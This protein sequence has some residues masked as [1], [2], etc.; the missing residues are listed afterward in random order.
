MSWK[1]PWLFWAADSCLP[2]SESTSQSRN[3]VFQARMPVRSFFDQ[4][5]APVSRSAVASRTEVYCWEKS[6]MPMA[7]PSYLQGMNCPW[8]R[9]GFIR[10]AGSR[11]QVRRMSEACSAYCFRPV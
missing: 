10:V 1:V 4:P 3:D 5:G 2:K 6:M 7:R 8:F 11:N 9:L